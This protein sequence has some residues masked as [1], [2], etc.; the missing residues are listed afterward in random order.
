MNYKPTKATTRNWRFSASYD[1]FFVNHKNV[2]YLSWTGEMNFA[3]REVMD[4]F[5][6][7]QT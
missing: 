5:K 6:K 4:K 1:I 2:I 3:D 7:R